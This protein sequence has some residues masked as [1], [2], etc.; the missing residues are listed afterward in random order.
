LLARARFSAHGALRP[1]QLAT[2]LDQKGQP[3]GIAR[4]VLYITGDASS[5]VTGET[6][7]GTIFEGCNAIQIAR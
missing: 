1:L 4:A 2:S 6:L 3:E 5:F 7:D